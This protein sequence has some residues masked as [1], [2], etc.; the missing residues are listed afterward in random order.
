MSN[1]ISNLLSFFKI[2]AENL[3]KNQIISEINIKQINIDYYSNNKKGDLASNLYLIIKKKIIKSDYDFE[4]DLD[5]KIKSLEFI[6][7]Y[8]IS[9]NG[10]INFFIKKKFVFEN[11][12]NIYNKKFLEEKGLPVP[13]WF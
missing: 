2:F 5:E 11:L 12:I 9:K 6:D 13:N 7:N 4:K 1:H 10:F 8:I 3:Q